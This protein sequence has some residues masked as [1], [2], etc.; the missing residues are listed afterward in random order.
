VLLKIEVKIGSVLY[1]R[2]SGGRRT[3]TRE[4][5]DFGAAHP[6][7]AQPSRHGGGILCLQE[8]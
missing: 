1:V 6:I 2:L 4:H 3:S 7:H 8:Q 5:R